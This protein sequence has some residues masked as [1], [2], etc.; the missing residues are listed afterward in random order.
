MKMNHRADGRRGA[1][2]EET[3]VKLDLI[4]PRY[5]WWQRTSQSANDDNGARWCWRREGSSICALLCIGARREQR[6]PARLLRQI[7]LWRIVNEFYENDFGDGEIPLGPMDGWMETSS[8]QAGDLSV[9]RRRF[10]FGLLRLGIG[11][12]WVSVH[13]PI[14][15]VKRCTLVASDWHWW[16]GLLD[17]DV[18]CDKITLS[19]LSRVCSKIWD[20]S[21]DGNH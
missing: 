9:M 20:N 16:C 8:K 13:C 6:S 11:S 17:V 3:G 7:G 5:A 19:W 1:T 4:I 10:Q 2:P 21:T 15:R 18:G 12:I 14:A